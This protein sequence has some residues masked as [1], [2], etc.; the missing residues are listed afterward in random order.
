MIKRLHVVLIMILFAVGVQAQ[1]T[2]DKV[3]RGLV[4]ASCRNGGNLVSWKIFAD[5]YFDVTYNLYKNGNIIAKNL[6]VSSYNDNTGTANDKYQVAP[7][8]AN[9]NSGDSTASNEGQLSAVSTKW[10]YSD[11]GYSY[12]RVPLPSVYG[13][14]G[15]D[16]STHYAIEDMCLAD[17]TGDGIVEFITK[18]VSDNAHDTT[19]KNTYHH[20]EIY[21]VKGN[22]LWWIDLGPNMLSGADDQFDAVAYDWDGDGKAEVLLRGADNMIIHRADGTTKNVGSTTVDTRWSGIEYTSTGN[23]YLLYLNGETGE[24]YQIMTYPLPRGND[25]DWGSGIVGHRSTKHY[26]GAPFLDGRH[27]SIFLG[28]G[29]YTKHHFKAFDVDPQTHALT[30]RWEWSNNGGWSD[31]WYG[32]GYHNF[33]IADVDEDGRDEIVFGSMVIDDNGKGLSTTGLGHGDSQ[34][35]S[36]FDPYRKGLEFFA[37]NEDEPNMNYRNATTA[38]I[39]YRSVGTSDD[40]RA[41]CANFSNNFPGCLGRSVN[42]GL[43]STVAD[44]E[45]SGGPDTASDKSA[46]FWSHLNFRIYWD[47]DLLSEILDSPGTEKEAAVY[48]PDNGREFTSSGCKMNNWSKNNPCATADIY[49]DWR[50]EIVVREGD[51]TAF[52]IYTTNY[53]NTYRIPTLWHEPQYRQAMVWQCVGYNQPPH[54]S[55]FLGELEGITELPP[56]YTMTGRTEISNGGD[57][58]GQYD[59][60]TVMMCETN[61]T[62]ISITGYP[63]PN[64]LLFNVPSWVQGTNSSNTK[65]A[66]VNRTYYTCNVSGTGIS[67]AGRLVKQG[68]GILN[69]GDATYNHTG[70]TDIW[71]GTVIFNGH[72]E[73]SP[74]WLNRF[75]ELNS[76]GGVFSSIK[77]SYE[78]ALKPGG[79]NNIGLMEMNSLTMGFGSKI[80]F[81]INSEIS[82]KTGEP[83]LEADNIHTKSL[84]IE[85]K[86]W[87]YGPM[88]LQPRFV[89]NV[90]TKDGKLEPGEYLLGNVGQIS[91]KLEN[92]LIEGI[93]TSQKAS[94][95]VNDDNTIY[96]VVEGLRDADYI[97]WNGNESSL[98]NLANDANFTLASNPESTDNLFVTNDK[99][100]FDDSASKFN[101][102]LAGELQA[103]SVIVNSTKAYT[104]SGSGALIGS[105]KFVKQGTGITTISNDNTYT[106]G[107]RLSGG[108]V[109]VS[110]LSNE[111]QAYGNLGGVNTIASRF[112]M[113]NGATLNNTASVTQGS[114]MQMYGSEGGVINASATFNMNKAVSGTM[115]TK[116]GSGSLIFFSTNS[117]QKLVIQTGTVDLRSGAP[118]TTVELQGGTLV[119]NASNTS[120]AIVV[121]KGKSATWKLSGTYYLGYANKLT[122]EGTLTIVPTNTVSRVRITADWSKF[123]GTIKHTTK[124]IWLPLDASTGLPNGTLDIASG[125]TVT[126][127]CKTFTIGKLTGSGSLAHPVANFQNSSA[128]TGNNTWRVGNSSDEL[129]NF[130]F[131]GT[132][133]DG[134]QTNKAN[135]V[136]IG[137]CKMTVSGAWDNT[138]TVQVQAG[139]LHLS[140]KAVLGKGT[141]TVLANATLSGI[142]TLTN[143][144][145]TINGTINPG[146]NENSPTGSIDFSGKNVTV[147]TNGEILI[148]ARQCATETSNGC[149]SLTNIG[150]MTMNGKVTVNI[151]GQ[152]TLAEGDSIRIWTSSSTTGTPKLNSKCFVIDAEKG[153]YWDDSRLNEG[154]LFV[155]KEVP[156]A[157]STITAGSNVR[158]QVFSLNGHKIANVEGNYDMIEE[159]VRQANPNPGVYLI[160]ISDGKA[161]ETR[162]ILIK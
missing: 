37:C 4:V 138:G 78:S 137:T 60:A 150:K 8:Y 97:I 39:Y 71:A 1:R 101:V 144:A 90:M 54:L 86:N 104:F 24:D 99:V 142:A 112:V 92:V 130:T 129:G 11:G 105:T 127:V 114:P 55:N 42:T 128:V 40:G 111:Y 135:F 132:I 108:T 65:E 63:S 126:N 153:L 119:D 41:I 124:D 22:R 136:K 25:T 49:G 83:F 85:T 52:R 61:N 162:K 146:L 151:Y 152:N 79:E 32:N 95:K 70:K 147:G 98:W 145:T 23:E 115:L 89:F 103:D 73:N 143:S 148:C 77:M 100:L 47:D 141:L 159:R 118:A 21:D 134:G 31:P 29:C 33:G 20:I 16:Q 30:L 82:E 161:V 149:S 26:F 53:P 84:S 139:Q 57:I 156:S 13:R 43:I 64:V 121:P 3:D 113:E 7:V 107:T 2:T 62:N 69:L 6:K 81:D 106:G 46:L 45:V 87:D 116:K 122:G 10:P 35:C 15:T 160:R 94:L 51:N 158:A 157:I 44:R 80:V 5:E 125:C 34:H 36:D 12:L 96:L 109:R 58:N 59:G 28:R 19:N 131:A 74:V 50:E 117:L 140:S 110:S 93:S 67:G 56:P 123:T 155:T 38:K 154:L 91:G 133:T 120:H 68:D 75:T 72:M 48:D 76:N 66:V 102:T 9:P 14:D 18:R 17:V 88:Y 27:A